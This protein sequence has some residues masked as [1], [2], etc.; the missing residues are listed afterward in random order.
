MSSIALTSRYQRNRTGVILSSTGIPRQAILH[1]YPQS[2]ILQVVEHLWTRY[3]RI[4]ILAARYYG[5][6]TSWWMIA[7][8]NP[9]ILDWT[10]IPIGTII[11]IP[12]VA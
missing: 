11:R 7:E 10:N 3:D 12:S 5:N 4:D 1:R 9:R 2:L 8:S 6:E